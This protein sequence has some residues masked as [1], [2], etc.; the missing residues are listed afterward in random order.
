MSLDKRYFDVKKGEVPFILSCPHGGYKKPKSLPDKV[1]GFKIPDE[2]TYIIAKYIIKKL[3]E[4]K[5][6]P[7]YILNKI[8]RC[9]LD[10]NRPTRF[11]AAFHQE[12]KES[13]RLHEFYHQR[14]DNFAKE[15][16]EKY[17][18]CLIIDLHGF[19]KPMDRYPDIIFG[20][21]FSKTLNVVQ[22][23]EEEDCN[24][25]WGCRDLSLE[26]SK[27]FSLDDGLKISDF[28]L[29]Y[30]GGYIIYQFYKKENINAIQLEIAKYI[31]KDVQLT[32]KFIGSFVRAIQKIFN[33]LGKLKTEKDLFRDG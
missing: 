18:T 25:Y 7:Y 17:G 24:K 19:T 10:L 21:V 11:Q 29:S 27:H 13:K 30:S 1:K 28:N 4:K 16:I 32:N 12:C 33:D 2:N 8:H 3:K 5:I 22:D 6:H 14:L 20:H 23:V 31:R 9:K 26:L 15:C